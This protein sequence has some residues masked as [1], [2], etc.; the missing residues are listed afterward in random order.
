M[1]VVEKIVV[2]DMISE[3]ECLCHEKLKWFLLYD[4]HLFKKG[5]IVRSM[6][7]VPIYTTTRQKRELPTSSGGGGGGL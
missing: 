7:G 6:W 5:A 4:L 1:C 2:G 3:I